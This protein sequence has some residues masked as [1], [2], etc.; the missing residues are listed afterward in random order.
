MEK[1]LKQ[2]K[3]EEFV[4]KLL[5]GEK[6]FTFVEL[7]DA[8]LSQHAKK[9][10]K[11]TRKEREEYNTYFHWGAGKFWDI[12]TDEYGEKIISIEE[13][14]KKFR[15][16]DN[17]FYFPIDISHSVLT[18]VNGNGL[19]LPYLIGEQTQFEGGTFEKA[20]FK[21]SNLNLSELTRTNFRN[22]RF[23]HANL[24]RSDIRTS[25]LRGADLAYTIL[26]SASLRSVD[27]RDA[28]IDETDLGHTFLVN[29]RADP[30]Q[31]ERINQLKEKY[32]T[33]K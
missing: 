10:N 7:N 6:D 21:H 18:N 12:K 32:P 3:E 17:N 16:G 11:F 20:N 13:L 31:I 15:L 30:K 14:A 23:D 22:S 9:I 24:S 19:E 2:M 33:F 27:I 29:V 25:D 1:Q 28:N 4:K 26:D 5:E 8:N